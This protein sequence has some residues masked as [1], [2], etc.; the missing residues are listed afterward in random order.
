MSVD[1]EQQD[2]AVEPQN[3]E[4]PDQDTGKFTESPNHSIVKYVLV[5]QHHDYL[6]R[7]GNRRAANG[8]R[9]EGLGAF[10]QSVEVIGD[11]LVLH[12]IRLHSRRNSQVERDVRGS[13]LLVV[14]GRRHV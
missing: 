9:S 8:N 7:R 2:H 6:K 5:G 3:L 12:V 1:H 14:F 11:R 10:T 13:R 4:Q